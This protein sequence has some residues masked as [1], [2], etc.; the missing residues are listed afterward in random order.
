MT[1]FTALFPAKILLVDDHPMLRRGLK[2]LLNLEEDVQ[3]VAEAENGQQALD[4]L[5]NHDVDLIVLDNNMPVLTG[6]ETLQKIRQQH[7]TGKVILFTVSDNSEDVQDALE[8]GADGYLLKD[9]EPNDI[10]IDIRKILKGELVIS[11]S[12]APVLTKAMRKPANQ[13]VISERQVVTMIAQGMSNKMIGNKLDIAESTVKVH[14]KHVLN[15][16][17]LRSRV[18][19]AVWAVQNL[20]V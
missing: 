20:D 10:I 4:Y 17:Q 2:D 18:E 11:P 3:V 12:L 16:T 5:Q 13:H 14:V 7:I 19:V 6:I 15:K 1:I 9:M 8:L